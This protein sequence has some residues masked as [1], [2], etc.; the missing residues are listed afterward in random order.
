MRT[1]YED[2]T[3]ELTEAELEL[4]PN[5]V[6]RLSVKIGE[7]NAITN[8]QI[9]AA[10]KKHGVKLSSVRVKKIIQYIRVNRLVHCLVGTQKGYYVAAKREE[11]QRYL[12]SLGQDLRTKTYLY[13]EMEA[14]MN[15]ELWIDASKRLTINQNKNG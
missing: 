9:R 11:M 2:L 15:E 4:V 8:N 3:F 7:A 1:N 12:E 5:F 14:Q 13:D 10:Y 6:K